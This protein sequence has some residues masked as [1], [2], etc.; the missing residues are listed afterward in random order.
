MSFHK[1][2]RQIYGPKYES[3][4]GAEDAPALSNVV[5]NDHR[6]KVQ[7]L[8]LASLSRKRHQLNLLRTAP[9][10]AGEGMIEMQG[11]LRLNLNVKDQCSEK[12]SRTRAK[13]QPL[14]NSFE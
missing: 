2:N 10:Q 8:S 9:V 12:D 1:S 7:A 4:H 13:G 6:R 14:R 5:H 3:E 11:K